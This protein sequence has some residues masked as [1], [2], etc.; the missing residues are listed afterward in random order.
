MRARR[1]GE[2]GKAKMAKGEGAAEMGGEGAWKTR[3]VGGR[4]GITSKAIY[5]ALDV[6]TDRVG[7]DEMGDTGAEMAEDRRVTGSLY[8]ITLSELAASG[9]KEGVSR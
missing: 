2:A 5:K 4:V 3:R 7:E 1:A 8:A 6:V 9:L